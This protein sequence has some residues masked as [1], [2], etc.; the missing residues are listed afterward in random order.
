MDNVQDTH[1]EREKIVPVLREYVEAEY[2][3]LYGYLVKNI[4]LITLGAFGFF[5]FTGAGFIGICMLILGIMLAAGASG[6]AIGTVM[7]IIG[8][9]V[10]LGMIGFLAV[11]LSQKFWIKTFKLD[12]MVDKALHRSGGMTLREVN[13]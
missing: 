13:P 1:I 7:L 8:G 6:T 2:G 12:A 11:A 9:L 10:V 4:R 3:R 5:V